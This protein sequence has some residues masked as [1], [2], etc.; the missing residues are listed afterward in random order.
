MSHATADAEITTR[1]ALEILGYS[2]PSTVVRWVH[3]GKLTPSRKLPGQSGAYLFWRR[4]IE[5]IKAE[6]GVVA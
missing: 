2:N 1:Q 6:R 3:E 4:D 5:R